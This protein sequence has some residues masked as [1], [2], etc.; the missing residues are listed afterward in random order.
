MRMA[1]RNHKNELEIDF[2]E[3]ELGQVGSVDIWLADDRDETYLGGW[4]GYA[5]ELSRRLEEDEYFGLAKYLQREDAGNQ[6]GYIA[7]MEV[8]QGITGRGVGTAMIEAC[9]DIMRQQGVEVVFFH[10][11]A[12]T[13]SSDEQLERLYKRVGFR[14]VKCCARDLW[15][16]MRMDL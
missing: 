13:R 4:Y 7:G 12:G 1:R 3:P 11:S 5:D 16:V 9:L 10:R 2:S 8:R 6:I 14:N 15:P